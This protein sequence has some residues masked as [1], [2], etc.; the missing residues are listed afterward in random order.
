MIY[1]VNQYPKVTHT[2]VRT[3]IAAVER[4]GVRVD[5][6]AIRR[7][8]SPLLDP[9]DQ[10]EAARTRVLLDAGGR[11]LVAALLRHRLA[12][13]R[14][15]AAALRMAV[16]IGWRSAR[17]VTAISPTWPRPACCCAGP[18]SCALI[19]C[20]RP[21]EP[22]RRRWRCCAASWADRRTASPRTDRKSS[23]APTS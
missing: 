17:G 22:T 7:A 5:R 8:D 6:I 3:E 18:A 2:F 16:R 21:S 14:Q 11:G 12:T 9:V 1:L 13:P 20:T 15:F 23:T 19:T 10:R 4:A